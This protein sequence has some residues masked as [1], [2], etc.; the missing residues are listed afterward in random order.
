MNPALTEA[1]VLNRACRLAADYRARID[2]SPF[3]LMIDSGY[4]DM[5]AAIDEKKIQAFVRDHPEIIEEWIA[6]SEDKRCGGWYFT[7]R[8]DRDEFVVGRVEAPKKVE[9]FREPTEPCARFIK[10]ELES[11]AT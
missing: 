5:R 11:M 7:K 8:L 4:A 9:S 6:Y 3:R 2:I 10:R 1:E